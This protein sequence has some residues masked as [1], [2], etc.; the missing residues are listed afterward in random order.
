MNEIRKKIVNMFPFFEETYI[1][2]LGKKTQRTIYFVKVSSRYFGYEVFYFVNSVGRVIPTHEVG[3]E[4]KDLPALFHSFSTEREVLDLKTTRCF[5]DRFIGRVLL[6][7]FLKMES[8]HRKN[9]KNNNFF[10]LN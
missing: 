10:S 4:T 9:I 6:F 3:F 7:S 2:R 8:L 1:F 5:Y